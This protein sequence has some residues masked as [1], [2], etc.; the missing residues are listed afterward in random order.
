MKVKP[1]SLAESLLTEASASVLATFFIENEKDRHVVYVHDI[2][3]RDTGEIDIKYSTPSEHV[4]KEWLYGEIQ[5]C[6]K[7]IYED[8]KSNEP[9]KRFISKVIN[10]FRR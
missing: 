5:K 2:V 10:Y 8:V 9:K 7:L 4:D 1:E 6:V 3:I